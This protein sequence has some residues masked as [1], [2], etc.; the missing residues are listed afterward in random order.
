M[1]VF[2]DVKSRKGLYNVD[3]TFLGCLKMMEFGL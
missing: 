2:S 1:Q 3:F